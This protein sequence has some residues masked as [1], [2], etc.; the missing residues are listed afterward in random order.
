M[1]TIFFL[2]FNKI[3]THQPVISGLIKNHQVDVNI[4][5]AGIDARN[6]GFMVVELSGTNG[7]VEHSVVFL[8]KKNVQVEEI[9]TRIHYKS[10][11]C[12]HC[13]A[14]TAVCFAGALKM[15]PLKELVFDSG[16]C[17]ACSMCTKACPFQLFTLKF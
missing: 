2:Q 8:R 11:K 6:G 17:I 13:G 4:L 14:C 15:S 7:S 12:V 5:R 10:E 1:K 3:N 16:K 9:S